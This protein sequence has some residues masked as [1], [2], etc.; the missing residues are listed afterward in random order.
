M[1]S[2]DEPSHHGPPWQDPRAP[3]PW[4]VTDNRAAL[5]LAFGLTSL[6]TCGITGLPAVI[7]G[8]RAQT[9]IRQSRGSLT[10]GSLAAWGIATG[11]LGSIFGMLLMAAVVLSAW[12]DS[13]REATT[14]PVDPQP[15]PEVTAPA[16][17]P[18]APLPPPAPA[19]VGAIRVVDL[20]PTARAT[21]HQQLESEYRRAAGAHQMLILMTSK[22]KCDVCDEIATSLT[23]SRMQKALA[24][25]EIVRADVDDF[26]EE[27]HENGML[28][29][30]LP[31][32]YKIGGS[33]HP[34]D[35][36]SAGEWAENVPENMAPVLGSFV[37][38][39]LKVRRD[40]SSLGTAL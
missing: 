10:G 16:W 18:T 8:V 40:P 14:I 17:A 28:E 33:L 7:L 15:A 35:A 29:P 20:D 11:V 23:D 13:R 19:M 1:A 3:H 39:T 31:W 32:F 25:V 4:P 37:A 12:V 22:K 34:T 2:G 36:V 24:H 30:T 26:A 38:G 21:F 6:I 9:A 5:S 27:L